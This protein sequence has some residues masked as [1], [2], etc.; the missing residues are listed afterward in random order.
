MPP[1]AQRLEQITAMHARH[2]HQLR[3]VVRYRG[4]ADPEVVDDACEHAWMKLLAAE[5]VD[6]R[7]PRWSALAWLT[8]CAVRHARL[9]DARNGAPRPPLAR[10]E[11][12]TRSTG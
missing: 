2:D 5:E 8:T 3:R 6:L 11:T 4:S 12:L 1:D 10:I 7:P 9:L